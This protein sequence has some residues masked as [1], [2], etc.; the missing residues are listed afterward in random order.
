ME[1]SFWL[2]GSRREVGEGLAGMEDG[3]GNVVDE[4]RAV[5]LP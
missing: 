4:S 1:A 2:D 5:E 3:I